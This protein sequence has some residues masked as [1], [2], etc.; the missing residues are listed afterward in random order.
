MRI[1]F[2]EEEYAIGV[3]EPEKLMIKIIWKGRQ[4]SEQYRA[5]FQKALKLAEERVVR[6]YISDVRQQ[7][8]VSPEDRKWFQE[9]ALPSAIERGLIK[10]AVIFAGNPFKKYYL[11]NILNSA[12]LFGLPLN[13]FY[14]P[15]EAENWLL[16]NVKNG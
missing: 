15:D 6:F 2:V 16:E 10:A 12:K 7:R 14:N 1:V 11:N 5:T 9:V 3:Y 8:V 13:F 4:T